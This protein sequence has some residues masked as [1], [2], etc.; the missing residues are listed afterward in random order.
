MNNWDEREKFALKSLLS[1]EK[2][3]Y[4]VLIIIFRFVVVVW[5][6]LSCDFHSWWCCMLYVW[7]IWLIINKLITQKD[8]YNYHNYTKWDNHNSEC[9]DWHNF[10]LR[11]LSSSV[12]LVSKWKRKWS[13]PD[14]FS[15]FLS[16]GD[17]NSS[18]PL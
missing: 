2:E 6:K 5:Y 16:F 9:S 17:K 13:S 1:G 3:L 14:L 18:F 8:L 4:A 11:H 10:V 7:C 15:L 12:D